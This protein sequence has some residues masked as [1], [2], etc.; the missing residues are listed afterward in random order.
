MQIGGYGITGPGTEP[1]PQER[2]CACGTLLDREGM[3][4]EG[5]GAL[6][7]DEWNEGNALPEHGR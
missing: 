7:V 5:C 2:R 3:C 4:R 1:I 6:D